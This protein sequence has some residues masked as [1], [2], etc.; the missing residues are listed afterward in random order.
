MRQ[1]ITK[2]RTSD[3]RACSS[4][5]RNI[6][7]L[8][9]TVS[10]A[11][12]GSGIVSDL[13]A[14]GPGPQYSVTD[15]GAFHPTAINNS[16]NVVGYSDGG[17]V[18]LWSQ[19]ILTDLGSMGGSFAVASGLN[20]SGQIA[21]TM[22][23]P[24]GIEHFIFTNGSTLNIGAPTDNYYGYRINNLGEAA[25]TIGGGTPFLYSNGSFQYLPL[26]GC[27]QGIATDVNDSQAITGSAIGGDCGHQSAVVWRNGGMQ[28][29]PIPPDCPASS[30][31]AQINAGGQIV[32]WVNCPSAR[33]I[34]WQPDSGGNYGAV[35]LGQVANSSGAYPLGINDVGVVVGELDTDIGE[36]SFLWDP[37]NGL[38][39]LNSLIP[40]GSGMVLGTAF[41][42]NNGGMII[43]HWIVNGALHAY[44]LTPVTASLASGGTA[45]MWIGLK[46]SDD[47]GTRFDLLVQLQKNGSVVS[48]G[49][50]RCIAGVTRNPNQALEAS[51]S[52]A[53]FAPVSLASGDVIS[54]RVST[55]I[56]TNNDDT[57]CAGHSNAQGL[58]LYYDASSRASHAGIE[59]SPDPLVDFFPRT[60]G[61]TDRLDPVA[62]I[63]TTPLFKDSA[64]L[65]F[66][67]GN[68]WKPIGTWSMSIAQ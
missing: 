39:D 11:A 26:A 25:N 55:R 57:K 46:N 6:A 3:D 60:S 24:N 21:G 8:L 68:L 56:G 16:G 2:M 23:T 45:R 43:G 15:L 12:I 54:V 19:G 32:G 17:H 64:A 50:T 58:R 41:G 37:A 65:N 62:P 52:F 7:V 38:R 4:N 66:A 40:Q 49:L 42:I 48:E 67:N 33:P 29:L 63:G 36:H 35:N 53:P 1:R 20:D 59:M 10:C 61:V 18:L 34:L 31:S 27:N 30:Q 47:Q 14:Q 28:I 44:L 9:F 5:L 51:A 22:S 13:E